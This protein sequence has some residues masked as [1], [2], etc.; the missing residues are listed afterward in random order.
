[1]RRLGLKK[2][3]NWLFE[4]LYFQRALND[5]IQNE[6][7]HQEPEKKPAFT[8]KMFQKS[9]VHQ[10]ETP[11]F[12]NEIR[13][14]ESIFEF[15]RWLSNDLCEIV[16]KRQFFFFGK[17]FFPKFSNFFAHFMD[18]S[19][20]IGIFRFFRIVPSRIPQRIS[21]KKWKYKIF[22]KFSNHKK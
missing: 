17:F 18:I 8:L 6:M 4:N 16:I 9:W 11:D 5:K 1:M 15:N 13:I 22:L 2:W 14:E 20:L 19:I 3:K 10:N 12:T 7:W 21:F